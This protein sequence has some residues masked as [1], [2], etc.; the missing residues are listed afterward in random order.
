M[1]N[2]ALYI[3]VST[4]E[5]A[6]E[7]YSI[8][9]QKERL[10]RYSEA[11]GWQIYD[12]YTDPGFSGGSM[13]RPGLQRLIRDVKAHKVDKVLV[14]KL[15][16]LSRSQLDTLYLIEKV[17]L[18]N[19]VDF[20]SMN[21]NF[22]ADT[23]FG[24]AAL[25]IMATFAQ[26]E[27]E[28]IRE[29]LMMGKQARAKTGKFSGGNNIPYGY[30]YIDHE[31]VPNEKEAEIVRDIFRR[32]LSGGSVTKIVKD[33]EKAGIRSRGG[34]FHDST[35]RNVLANRNSVG[36]VRF[37]GEWIQ[38]THPAIVD[39][40]IFEAVQHI[41]AKKRKEALLH[42]SRIGKANSYLSGL[43]FCSRCGARFSKKTYMRTC[44][45][46][47]Y[48]YARYG[49]N[50]RVRD[51][52][53]RVCECD[54]KIWTMKELD[55]LIFGEIKKLKLDPDAQPAE[56]APAKDIYASEIEDI[57]RRIRRLMDL[58]ESGTIDM[59]EISERIKN[60]NSRRQLLEA[61]QEATKDVKVAQ[62]AV[63]SFSE[64]LENGTL[65]QVRI[66][67][68]D[69]IRRIDIDGEDVTIQWNF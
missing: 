39:K 27:R 47:P 26:F 57:D 32:Y 52:R 53:R 14:Y 68:F 55:D 66:L 36:E 30:D 64:V 41:M 11:M 69:I 65:E 46:V 4:M 23:P 22:S 33:Y 6:T 34:K 7:G 60:L 8:G 3:R 54:N 58:Y 29:R 5:Q 13:D 48:N 12:T 31:L 37:Q 9:E 15:D 24:R 49:C 19:N 35:I 67:L 25:G 2:V 50:N 44:K 28:Q 18:V 42:N 1:V 63:Q 21:E 62:R 40:D 16:R 20:V 45:G 10:T 51:K 43:L 17:F 59:Q 61:E 38:G 56:Q